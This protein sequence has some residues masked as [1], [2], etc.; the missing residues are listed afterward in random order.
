MESKSTAEFDVQ[1]VSI[2]TTYDSSTRDYERALTAVAMHLTTAEVEVLDDRLLRSSENANIRYAIFYILSIYY[3]RNRSFLLLQKLMNTYL[4]EFSGQR[5]FP[6]LMSLYYRQTNSADQIHQAVEEARRAKLNCPDHAGVLNNF[7]ELVAVIGESYEKVDSATLNEALEAIQ[8]AIGL[9]RA[10]P[11]FY[12]TQG[13]LLALKGDVERARTLIQ[14]AINMED[15]TETDYAVRLG[16]YQ[17]HLLGVLI[18]QFKHRLE[19][20][21][22]TAQ[23]GI[24]KHRESVEQALH[25][26][27][28]KVETAVSTAQSSNL[29]FLGFFTAL[30]SFVVGS[31]QILSHEPLRA[32]EH[33]IIVLG[34][35]M[36]LVVLAFTMVLRPASERWAKTYWVGI[37]IS[38]VLIVGG[39][40]H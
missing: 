20:D 17:S 4:Q 12:A 18:L 16:D 38:L 6:H 2:A 26:Q 30:L 11:K 23:T 34:G 7:A 32:A 5:T 39:L 9:D 40:L 3:R 21:L 33:L 15:T 22:Q 14:H 1:L 36:L 19:A 29:Q 31:T 10:Y 13:R 27:Q 25:Q 24:E 37:A 35:V 8:Q 28:A